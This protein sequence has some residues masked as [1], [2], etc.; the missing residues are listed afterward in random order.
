MTHS[1]DS[2]SP[3]LLLGFYTTH[4]H[5]LPLP[6]SVSLSLSVYVLQPTTVGFLGFLWLSHL[7]LRIIHNIIFPKVSPVLDATGR[8]WKECVHVHVCVWVR[9]G[10]ASE[11]ERPSSYPAVT[12]PGTAK[13][14]SNDPH[15]TLQT[16]F[17]AGKPTALTHAPTPFEFFVFQLIHPFICYSFSGHFSTLAS[18]CSP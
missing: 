3:L 17:P 9:G 2:L 15:P 11:K 1:H 14:A 12:E 8:T 18:L 6:P 16:N 5:T 4:T 7:P 13:I 10:R